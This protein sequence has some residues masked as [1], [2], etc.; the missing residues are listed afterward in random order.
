MVNRRGGDMLLCYYDWAYFYKNIQKKYL[1]S[2]VQLD[3]LC[4][5][6][7]ELRRLTTSPPGGHMAILQAAVEVQY[8][9]P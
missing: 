2:L 7:E 8:T 1:N 6:V 3:A 5:A 4:P 9:S